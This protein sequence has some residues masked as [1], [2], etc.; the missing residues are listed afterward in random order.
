M[1]LSN[2]QACNTKYIANL[3]NLGSKHGVVMK[4]FILKFDIN[5]PNF[6]NSN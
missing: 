1:A 3:N 6:I 5:W 4:F 2:A